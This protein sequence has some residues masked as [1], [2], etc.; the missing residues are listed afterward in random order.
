M[1]CAA[2][3]PAYLEWRRGGPAGSNP[4][5]LRHKGTG[6]RAR[7]EGKKYVAAGPR[8]V[9]ARIAVA[10]RAL[11]VEHPPLTSRA[12]GHPG[13]WATGVGK[14]NLSLLGLAA[15]AHPRQTG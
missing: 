4:S 13:C 7:T 8:R 1:G 15:A 10:I 2:L 12:G 6:R 5:P 11:T 14:G 9:N 3:H